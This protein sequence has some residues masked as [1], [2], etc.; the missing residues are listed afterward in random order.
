MKQLLFG[1]L[2]FLSQLCY[3]QTPGIDLLE[4]D[5]Q[6]RR[7]M[8][9]EPDSARILIKEILSYKGKLHDTVYGSTY[10][11]Y[12]YYH[13][14]KNNTDSSF[15]YYDRAQSFINGQKYPKLYARLLR[16]KAGTYKKRGENEK[17]LQILAEVEDIYHSI[18]NETGLAIVYGEIASNYNILL[19]TD[20]AINYL[21]KALAILEK[22]KDKTHLLSIKL[23]LANTY[24]NSG[25]LE[26]AAD[27]YQ[28]GLKACKEQNIVKSYSITLLNYGDCL[29]RQKKYTEAQKVLN[30]ALPGLKKFNDQEII[31]IVYSKLGTIQVKLNHLNAGETYYRI[32]FQKV[33][34]NKSLQVIAIGS[35]YIDILNKA[36]KYN[37]ALEVIALIDKPEFLQK[38]NIADKAAFEAQKAKVYQYINNTDKAITSLENS[39]KLQ[40]T[41]KHT[42]NTA[43]T[44]KLQQEFQNKYQK[45]KGESLKSV[46]T[47]LKEKLHESR[48]STLLPLLGICMLLLII[49]VVYIFRL[50]IHNKKLAI[51]KTKKEQL[52]KEYE[53]TKNLNLTDKE[54]L[55][56][57]KLELATGIVSLTS[58][59]G[60]ISRLIALCKENPCDLNIESIKG[61]LES[62]TSDDDY[63]TLFR[64]R[65]SETYAGFQENLKQNFPA[66]TQKDLFF[67]SMLKLNLPYKDMATL[68]QISPETIVKKKYRVKKKMGIET[69]SELE[70]ILL[71]TPL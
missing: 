53:D 69:E 2:V 43:T 38:A 15:Y 37:D 44:L 9:S 46:N 1:I 56:N 7:T 13:H 60:N 23:S 49:T 63:W 6:I 52:L 28:E 50:R 5:R 8:A 47:S 21:L 70:S 59:E 51:A 71:N 45:K 11:A 68:M 66:L 20:E 42:A 30:E 12:A 31:G 55:E 3:A 24:L 36:K 65:F 39:L 64:K 58:L 33:L 10:L 48:K 27:L 4:K 22:K 67:C 19:R 16:N 18:N 35:E 41:L 61:Q 34:A 57:K 17:S 32:A 26:F 40:D 54:S 14:L 62:L 25:N 29:T